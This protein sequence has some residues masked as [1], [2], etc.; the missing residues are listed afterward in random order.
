M[1][2]ADQEEEAPRGDACRGRGG[3]AAGRVVKG[4]ELGC[5]FRVPIAIEIRIVRTPLLYVV[6]PVLVRKYFQERRGQ[7]RAREGTTD[8]GTGPGR[9]GEAGRLR[10]EGV[11][12]SQAETAGQALGRYLLFWDVVL[13]R[14]RF[15]FCERRHRYGYPLVP[16]YFYVRHA[17]WGHT[18]FTRVLSY[19]RPVLEKLGQV[20]TRVGQERRPPENWYGCFT[21]WSFT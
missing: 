10:A 5:R 7:E 13:V 9:E 6:L 20:L 15:P 19:F 16:P 1:G 8:Q 3:G 4:G 2:F 21:S 17:R 11:C 12:K 18:T 14:L